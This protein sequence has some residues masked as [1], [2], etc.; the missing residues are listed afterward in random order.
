MPEFQRKTN[1]FLNHGMQWSRT[2]DAIADDHICFG[3]N[4]R[5]YQ[6]G[7]VQQRPGLTNFCTL[8]GG[9]SYIHTISRLNNYNPQLNLA[10]TFYVG[11]DQKLYVGRDSASLLNG[12]LNPVLTNLSG[13]PFSLVDSQTVGGLSGFKY[14]S[15]S[16]RMSSVGYYPGQNPVTSM[17]TVYDMGPTPPITTTIIPAVA[18]GGSLTGTYQWV[19]VIRNKYTGAQSNPSA[20]TRVTLA[21]PGLVCAAQ[22]ATFTT[23][24]T[25]SADFVTDVY[26]YGGTLFTW[27]LVGS[28]PGATA[29]VDNL[30]DA[31]ILTAPEPS[32][33]T[34]AAGVTRFNLFRPF[35]QPDISRFGTASLTQNANNVWILTWNTGDTFNTGWLPGSQ[36]GINNAPVLTIYQVIDSTH[37]ELLESAVDAGGIGGPYP[38]STP[39]GTLIAGQPV[40]HMWGPYGTGQTASVVFGCG[41]PLAPGTLFWTN[42]NDPDS[43]DLANSLVVTSPSE[44]LQ[45]GCQYDGRTF[46]WSTERMFEIFPSLSTPGQYYIQQV[47]SV[48]GIWAEWSLTVQSNEAGDISI[49]WVGKD[50]VYN[51]SNSTGAVC[52]T[53]QDLYP[54]FPHDNLPGTDVVVLYPFLGHAVAPYP[55]ELVGAPDYSSANMLYH[56]LCWHDKMLFYDFVSPFGGTNV[57]SSLV[58]DSHMGGWVSLDQYAGAAPVSRAPEVAGNNLKMGVGGILY[59]YGGVTDG[60]TTI[61]SR[62]VTRQDDLGD[63]KT[64]KLWGDYML[65]VAASA[66][67]NAFYSM[68]R[69]DYGNGVLN[70]SNLIG[71]TRQQRDLEIAAGAVNGLGILSVSFGLDLLWT[72]AGSMLYQ[73]VPTWVPKPEITG[74]RATDKTD[75]G[76]VGAKYL[77]GLCIEANT[78]NLAK[79][80]NILVDGTAVLTTSILANGQ[81]EIP[82]GLSPMIGSEF[83]VQ[84]ADANLWQVFSVRWTWDKYPD[85][86]ITTSPVMN[87]GTSKP[88]YVRGFSIP[89]DTNGLPRALVFK[90]DSSVVNTAQVTTTAGLKTSQQ[91]SLNPPVVGHQFELIPLFGALRAWYD[92]IRWDAEEW[93]EITAEYY[94]WQNLGTSGAKYLRGFE[95]PMET[96]GISARMQLLSDGAGTPITFTGVLTNS[97]VKTVFPFTPTTPVVG[98]EFQLVSLDPARVWFDEVKWEF[99]PWPEFSDG[100]QAFTDCGQPGAKFIQG[101]VIPIDTGGVP[102]S[103]NILYESGGVIVTTVIGPFTTPANCK[104]PVAWSFGT[105]FIAHE[106]Q[107]DAGSNC[108]VWGEEVKWVFEPLPELVTTYTTQQ[109]DHDLPGFHYLAPDAYIAYIGSSDAPRLTIITEY[110]TQA[111]TLPISN[112]VYTRAHIRI[113]PQKGKFRSYSVTSNGGIRLYKRDCQIGAKSWNVPGPFHDFQPFGEVSRLSGA[114]I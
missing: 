22:K 19:F 49:S 78:F 57:Y 16:T 31:D 15:D 66:T 93:P 54:F 70:Q 96:A 97:L 14:L 100:R 7:S 33:I 27:K 61:I 91:F 46:V 4:I 2:V 38:Y 26:R 92:E 3:R 6:D 88:K 68:P 5:V 11:I 52:L 72:P 89:M 24:A 98:H 55:A 104:T 58:F 60:G 36:I 71:A 90:Y 45:N 62:L 65:D 17:A 10:S 113:L 101:L 47:G 69:T 110:S 99:E 30:A 80:L 74:M 76:Y 28:S 107:I 85:L 112:G 43:S 39:A 48:K 56:R 83:Q 42:G 109:T 13:N 64:L 44:P 111:Y 75:D 20:P 82:I 86:A 21:A 12:A 87:M 8:G 23:P 9:A 94:P 84:P 103:L 50:G 40:R 53:D 35:P 59:D 79:S 73:Y 63:P 25:P 1:R 77:R 29:F 106:V 81:I 51:Y 32:Q 37:I 18:A 95:V 105:P 41:T 34:D 67:S 114:A 108:R 102:V